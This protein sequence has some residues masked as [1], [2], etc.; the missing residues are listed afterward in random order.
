M[1]NWHRSADRRQLTQKP[2]QTGF[3]NEFDVKNTEK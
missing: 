3:D 2:H 1:R